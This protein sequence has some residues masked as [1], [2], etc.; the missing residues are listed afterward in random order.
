MLDA[1]VD[2]VYAIEVVCEYMCVSLGGLYSFDSYEYCIE[3]S[4]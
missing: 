4:S 1:V 3:L 2:L